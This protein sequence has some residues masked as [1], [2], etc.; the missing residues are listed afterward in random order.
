MS[1]TH[2][3]VLHSRLDAGRDA[4]WQWITGFD[5]ITRELMPLMRMTVPRG[6]RRLD[7]MQVIPG[8]RLFR[9]VILLGGVVPVDYSDLTLIALTPGRGFVEESP[10]GSMAYWRHERCIEDRSDAPGVIL[11]DRLR[12]RPRVAAIPAL[13]LVRTLF[14]HRHA[15]LVRAFGGRGPELGDDAA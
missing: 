11:V 1:R 7:D 3:L 2:A 10:M 9:S 14:R 5:G 6:I 4:V 8:E 12:F 15:V 13:P